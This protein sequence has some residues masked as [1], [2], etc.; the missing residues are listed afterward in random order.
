MGADD[1]G[2]NPAEGYM[3]MVIGFDCLVCVKFLVAVMVVEVGM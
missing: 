3:M 2:V 1:S